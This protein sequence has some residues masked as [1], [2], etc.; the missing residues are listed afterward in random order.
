MSKLGLFLGLFLFAVTS[1]GA[2]NCFSDG[3]VGV[4]LTTGREYVTIDQFRMTDARADFY[5]L[6]GVKT[7]SVRGKFFLWAD[8]A[9][10][11]V[12]RGIPYNF[13][14]NWEQL[15]GNPYF[16]IWC[17]EYGTPSR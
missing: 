10:T 11:P 5:S 17:G 13:G 4:V 8:Y 3:N 9:K 2:V 7:S 12:I 6:N 14:R 15:Q 1:F 16:V